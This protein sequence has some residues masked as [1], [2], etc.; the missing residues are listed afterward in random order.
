LREVLNPSSQNK[1]F[2]VLDIPNGNRDT[3]CIDGGDSGAPLVIGGQARGL[4]VGHI[5]LQ[6]CHA[7]Y[8]SAV[9]ALRG[10]NVKL[11]TTAP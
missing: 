9:L 2:G 11:V 1:R 8:Q 5:G 6:R 10:L 3:P 4:M 7:Y